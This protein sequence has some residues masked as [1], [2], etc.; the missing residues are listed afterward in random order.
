MNLF[1]K[2]NALFRLK[3]SVNTK[4][5][6]LIGACFKISHYSLKFLMYA[7]CG[8]CN[9]KINTLDLFY[10]LSLNVLFIR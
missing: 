1:I 2:D 6:L 4:S 8:E 9:M 5:K 7:K 3:I 10:I